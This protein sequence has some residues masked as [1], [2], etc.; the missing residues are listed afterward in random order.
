MERILALI[1]FAALPAAAQTVAIHP[2]GRFPADLHALE[3]AV[4][5]APPG[6]TLVLQATDSA[7]RF[8]AFNLG[9]GL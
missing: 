8:T 1:L 4:A 7:G 9:D 3:A 2:T 6:A 5:A